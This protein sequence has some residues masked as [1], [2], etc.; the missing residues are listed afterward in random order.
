MRRGVDRLC[1]VCCYPRRQHVAPMTAPAFMC[2]P[3]ECHGDDSDDL[4]AASAFASGVVA[5][6]WLSPREREVMH[7]A[8]CKR[9]SN[10]EV[11]DAL[12]ITDSC[13]RAHVANS[14]TKL[15]ESKRTRLGRG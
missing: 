6:L 14:H 9:L 1:G 15:R 2:A 10:V 4:V 11:A 3:S 7:L 12:G 13:V 8:Y 5:A